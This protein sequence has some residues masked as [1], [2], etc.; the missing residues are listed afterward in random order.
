MRGKTMV[1][2]GNSVWTEIAP[3]WRRHDIFSHPYGKTITVE[4]GVYPRPGGSNRNFAH[5]PFKKCNLCRIDKQRLENLKK[6]I[7]GKPYDKRFKFSVTL[8]TSEVNVEP[9]II[10]GG[11]KGLISRDWRTFL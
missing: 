8:A 2:Y 7:A 5:N 3:H 4:F 6:A 1:V 10:A 11:A 9:T